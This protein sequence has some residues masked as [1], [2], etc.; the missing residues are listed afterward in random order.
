MASSPTTGTSIHVGSPVTMEQIERSHIEKI[1][2]STDS[3]EEASTILGI[4][5]AT[6]Y[7]KRKKYNLG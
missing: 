7:R 6:L 1:I 5:T 2:K 4:D 3:L